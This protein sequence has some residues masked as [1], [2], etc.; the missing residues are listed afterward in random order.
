M[1]PKLH[2][3]D[4]DHLIAELAERQHG[5]VARW[6]LLAAGACPRAIGRRIERGTL[7]IV[8]RGVYAL[9]HRRLTEK[10]RYMAAVLAA[11]EGAAVSHIPAARLHELPLGP[12]FPCHVTARRQHRSSREIVFHRSLLPADELTE[13]DGIPVT[14]TARTLLDLAPVIPRHRLRA[15]LSEVE[16]RQ[17]TDVVPLP[18]LLERYPRRRGAAVIRKLLAEAGF[19]DG[20]TQ[21]ELEARFQDF[22]VERRFPPASFGAPMTVA[23]RSIVADCAWPDHRLIVELDGRPAHLR[24]RNF[25]SDRARDRALLVAGWRTVRV[26]WRH[27]ERDGDAL[28]ADLW[29]LLGIES[30]VRDG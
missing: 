25:D 27:L 24:R 14:T 4:L 15:L 22:L 19:G 21:E 8:H 20:R 29:A 9:G 12:A 6:Q 18:V 10:G 23:G 1:R 26:T 5:V 16:Y 17:L 11:R 2:S 13:I 30:A 28:E 3:R 7:R